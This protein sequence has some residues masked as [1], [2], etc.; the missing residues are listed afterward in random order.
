MVLQLRD[1]LPDEI[2]G[3][4]W[5]YLDNP[6]FSPYVPIYAGNLSVATTYKTYDPNKY[7]ENSARWAIDFVDNL[8]NLKFQLIAEDVREVRTP[9]ENA[10][11]DDQKLVEEKAII[12][13]KRD[14]I[15][16]QE[17]LTNY[18]NGLMYDVTEMFIELRN[19]IITNYTNNHE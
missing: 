3:V 17:Y 10:I 15:I 16:A 12:L 2:G 1:W 13:Y 8:T 19:D 6:Y 4:Y 7:D 11:F 14:P 5:V 18:S 9:F